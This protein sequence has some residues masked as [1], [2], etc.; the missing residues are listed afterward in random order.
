MFVNATLTVLG[1]LSISL[2]N[3]PWLNSGAVVIRSDAQW[4]SSNCA[5]QTKPSACAPLLPADAL[6]TS[7]GSDVIGAYT[8][9]SL[10]W[11][12]KKGADPIMLTGVRSYAAMPD[13]NVLTQSF[14]AGLNVGNHAGKTNEVATAFP[15]FEKSHLDLGV[16]FYEGVQVLSLL[17]LHPFGSLLFLSLASL[18]CQNTR[19]FRWPAGKPWGAKDFQQAGEERKKADDDGAAM[20]LLLTAADGSAMLMSP[21]S[22]FFT[23]VQTESEAIGNFSIG[24]QGTV[25]TV[26]AGH[27]H[28]TLVVG[29]S[30]TRAATMRWGELLM[31]ASGGGK[32]RS[33][34]WTKHGDESLRSLSYYTD[35][36]SEV[37]G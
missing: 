2:N 5:T 7:S 25:D 28:Q 17:F 31:K 14:P 37:E 10:A 23:S 11:S 18:Q 34:R 35:N 1:A 24:M 33:M 8:E 32:T 3:A 22:D 20:P 9:Q 15:T 19:F 29:G 21:L 16:V 27:I 26:P 30:G 36:V 6:R 13:V 12:T 4:Y